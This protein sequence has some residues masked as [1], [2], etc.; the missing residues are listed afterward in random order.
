M[1]KES[2][3]NYLLSACLSL[4]L[5]TGCKA[6]DQIRRFA[7]GDENNRSPISCSV[8]TPPIPEIIAADTK[9]LEGIPILKAVNKKTSSPPSSPDISAQASPAEAAA[10][11]LLEG[12]TFRF[13]ELTNNSKMVENAR[14]FYTRLSQEVG[15]GE[16]AGQIEIPPGQE[17]SV[18]KTFGPDCYLNMRVVGGI[19]GNGVCHAASMLHQV[20]K[21][22]GL[23]V[24]LSTPTMIGH[25]PPIG[26]VSKEYWVTM[27]CDPKRY[28]KDFFIVNP[29][30]NYT[31]IIEWKIEND[32]IVFRV[33]RKPIS[34]SSHPN[35]TAISADKAALQEQLLLQ[36]KSLGIQTAE[37][38][39]DEKVLSFSVPQELRPPAPKIE[40]PITYW[41]GSQFYLR[42]PD[43]VWRDS[44]DAAV[45]VNGGKVDENAI[46]IAL[47]LVAL[48]NSEHPY[49]LGGNITSY[50]GAVGAMQ[51]MEETAELVGL[52]D[53]TNDRASMFAAAKFVVMV[54]GLDKETDK[55]S[56]V[57]NFIGNGGK[58]WNQHREQAKYVWEIWQLLQQKMQENDIDIGNTQIPPK[59][60]ANQETQ[61]KA[62]SSFED[63]LSTPLAPG[64][65]RDLGG[66]VFLRNETRSPIDP[67]LL[68]K[69]LNFGPKTPELIRCIADL[70]EGENLIIMFAQIDPYCGLAP[71]SK[72]EVSISSILLGPECLRYLEIYEQNPDA[73]RGVLLHELRHR[74]QEEQLEKGGYLKEL[75][76]GGSGLEPKDP[77]DLSQLSLERLENE[78]QK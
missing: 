53:R 35:E 70:P 47:L 27:W 66:N 55:T 7:D 38:P 1:A 40:E 5:I 77:K 13:S 60:T 63:L 51:F 52:L 61:E 9:N 46:K 19:A 44:F 4:T 73:S 58:A 26:G 76:P 71:Y 64:E 50:A 75:A 10:E 31:V 39:I 56:F 6:G 72:P 11:V 57:K 25:N 21:K 45:F 30:E 14:L 48:R 62:E 54:M 68:K 41:N 3:K 28:D 67:E 42:I 33:G 49:F 29:F 74:Y 12:E 16:Y 2:L 78:C 65:T 36:Y 20:V 32:E 69:T 59:K 18:N 15:G 17:I 22:A 37:T 34:S 8:E 24:K 23:E 43:V